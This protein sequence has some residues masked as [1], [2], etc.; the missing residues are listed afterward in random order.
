MLFITIMRSENVTTYILV[1]FLLWIVSIGLLTQELVKEVG[2]INKGLLAYADCA[3]EIMNSAFLGKFESFSE[4]YANKLNITD[5]NC[6]Y[7]NDTIVCNVKNET[8][9]FKISQ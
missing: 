2:K 1:P 9:M 5:F 3:S 7:N 4:C 6:I 8:Y